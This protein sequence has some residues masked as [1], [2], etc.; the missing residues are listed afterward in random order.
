LFDARWRRMGRRR[1]GG[2]RGGGRHQE[3]CCKALSKKERGSAGLG[4]VHDVRSFSPLRMRGWGVVEIERES[5]KGLL[6]S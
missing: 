5:Q 3:D 1:E 4:A 6:F 2:G